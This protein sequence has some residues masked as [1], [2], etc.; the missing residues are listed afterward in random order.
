[1][2]GSEGIGGVGIALLVAGVG[3]VGIIAGVVIQHHLTERSRSKD[4]LRIRY[5]SWVGAARAFIDASRRWWANLRVGMTPERSASLTDQL[6]DARRELEREASVLLLLEHRPEWVARIETVM[7]CLRELKWHD[8]LGPPS[9]PPSQLVPPA[10]SFAV[11]L[12]GA[13]D[14]LRAD[15]VKHHPVLSLPAEFD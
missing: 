1:M 5:A 3:V 2:D 13:V 9:Q 12:A 7:W 4:E 15:V 11:D 8:D 14:R 6:N 10:D